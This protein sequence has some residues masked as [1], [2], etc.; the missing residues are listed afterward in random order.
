M[1]KGFT[2]IE[3]LA[4]IVILAVIAII[5]IP[6]ITN[7]I[8]KAKIGALKDSGYGIINSGE[9]YIAN[10]LKNGINNNIKFNCIKNKCTS[11]SK[12]ISYKGDIN[13]GTLILTTESK[14]LVCV[15][16]GKNYALKL[17]NEKKISVGK[18]T[19]GQYEES[20]GTFE[21]VDDNA[22]LIEHYESRIDKLET[23]SKEYH[24]EELEISNLIS[25]VA[26]EQ[27]D[28]FYFPTYGYKYFKTD[29]NIIGWSGVT[30]SIKIIGVDSTN[31]ETVL[32]QNTSSSGK[33]IST[34]CTNINVSIYKQIKISM[35]SGNTASLYHLTL[36]D[37]EI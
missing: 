33:G 17:E 21:I 34:S 8:D 30:A 10:N 22:A 31:K 37:E 1:K 6:V 27:G 35:S 3:L 9:L 12:E 16:D 15:D 19:C 24:P 29:I 25:I 4:V 14:I 23:L 18:G 5:A 32:Y 7:V 26:F 20:N 36:Y 13:R 28:T 2:L 11:D